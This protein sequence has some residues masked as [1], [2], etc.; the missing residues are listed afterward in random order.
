MHSFP[1]KISL[2][3]HRDVNL[4]DG[5]QISFEC[6][7]TQF[8]AQT[9]HSDGIQFSG[10]FLNKYGPKVLLK[11]ASFAGANKPLP[12][13]FDLIKLRNMEP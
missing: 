6:S 12:E 8:T 3:H 4:S 5:L 11:N 7:L 10:S 9:E 13:L 1:S 2:R